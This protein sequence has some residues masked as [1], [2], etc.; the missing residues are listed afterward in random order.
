MI[1]PV[2]CQQ[3]AKIA[4]EYSEKGYT[5]L[6]WGSEHPEIKGVLGWAQGKGLPVILDQLKNA[7][8]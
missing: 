5:I 8:Q 4:Q 2:L 3:S 6:I 7:A 1:V